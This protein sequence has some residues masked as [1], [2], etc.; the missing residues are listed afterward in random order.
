MGRH[1]VLRRQV[2]RPRTRRGGRPPIELCGGTHVHAVGFIGPIKIVSEGSIG[3]NLRR[4][5]AVTGEGALARIHRR[6]GPSCATSPTRCWVSPGEVGDRVELPARAGEATARTS[7]APSAPRQAAAP[8][9]AT[10]AADAGDG[11]GRRPPRRSGPRRAAHARHRDPRRGLVRH[12][13]PGRRRCRRRQGGPGGCSEQG[14]RRG[15]RVGGR[16]R[17]RRGQGAGAAAPPST[18][19]WSR[20]AGRRSAPSTTPSPSSTRRCTPPP[21][22][23]PLRGVAAGSRRRLEVAPH[24]GGRATRRGC[25]P[26]RTA[27]WIPGRR[28]WPTTTRPSS[29]LPARSAPR[30]HRGGA[31]PVARRPTGPCGA[32]G[33]GRDR[34]A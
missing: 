10:L 18:P 9:R 7:S 6:R 21:G 22:D 14:P 24:G 28:R 4:I 20:A 32:V 25:W 23:A 26:A 33:A 15:R 17:P 2:R 19:T 27:P 31:A 29:P 30:D 5:E 3:A 12:R 8:R 13:R 16:A 34:G 1:R 11:A